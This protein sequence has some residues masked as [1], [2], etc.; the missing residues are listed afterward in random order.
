[1]NT[2]QG[3]IVAMLLEL[4]PEVLEAV[5]DVIE[6]IK[7]GQRVRAASAAMKAATLAAYKLRIRGVV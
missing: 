1:L 5:A 7:G 3:R 2:T 6:H 4:G